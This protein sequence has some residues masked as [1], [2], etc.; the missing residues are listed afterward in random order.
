VASLPNG[1]LIIAHNGV[2]WY[3]YIIQ[4]DGGEWTKIGEIENPTH[5]TWNRLSE[6]IYI[7]GN[8]TK[9]YVYKIKSKELTHLPMFDDGSYTQMR[10]HNDGVVLIE[11]ENGK[12]SNTKIQSYTHNESKLENLVRQA[13]S[14]FHPYIYNNKIFYAH[15]SCRLDCDPIIQE[16]WLKNLTTEKAK[17]LTLLNATSYLHSID[18]EGRYGFISS[19]TYG[20]YHI[21]RLELSTGKLNWLTAGQVTDSYPSVSKNGNLYFVRRLPSGINLMKISHKILS[22]KKLEL[23]IDE[24]K[25]IALPED[26]QKIRYLEISN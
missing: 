21:A 9:Y 20:Y 19:N 2:G 12:S 25:T 15:V 17:Q 1:M 22:N 26:I 4:E 16:V 7:K 10:A 14:Q 24:T 23:P 18:L 3:P 11:L 8:D 5:L 13:S 6:N